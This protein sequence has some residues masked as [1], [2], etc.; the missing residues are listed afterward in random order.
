MHRPSE[1]KISL[2]LVHVQ[3]ETMT[4]ESAAKELLAGTAGATDGM[5]GVKREMAEGKA[6]L[7]RDEVAVGQEIEIEGGGEVLSTLTT[8]DPHPLEHRLLRPQM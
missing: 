8:D 7:E 4:E 1:G 3:V 5:T 6:K 2:L